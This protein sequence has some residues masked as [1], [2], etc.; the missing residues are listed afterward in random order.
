[1]TATQHVIAYSEMSL[2]AIT[3]WFASHNRQGIPFFWPPISTGFFNP[4]SLV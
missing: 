4:G 2:E 3:I 1:M